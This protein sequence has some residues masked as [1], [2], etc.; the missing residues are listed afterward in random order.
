MLLIIS[1]SFVKVRNERKRRIFKIWK[2]YILRAACARDNHKSRSGG[3]LERAGPC[4]GVH[5]Y[6]AVRRGAGIDAER[7]DEVILGGFARYGGFNLPA[8]CASLGPAFPEHIPSYTMKQAVCV[9]HAGG[10]Q[11]VS[12]VSW[13]SRLCVAGGTEN[14][15]PRLFTSERT[16]GRRPDDDGGFNIEA[17]TAAQPVSV[18]RTGLVYRRQRRMWRNGSGINREEQDHIS[19]WKARGGL[20]PPWGSRIF[21]GE[22]DGASGGEGRKRK[23]FIFDTDEF[24]K[25]ATTME[26]LNS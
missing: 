21:Q 18:Y 25:P 2:T 10:I 6:E 12:G 26:I 4:A 9:R 14:I 11:R 16:L 8:R 19:R 15:E 1:S 22:G 3:R 7:I 13:T 20:R 5:R 24:P 23:S 17:G